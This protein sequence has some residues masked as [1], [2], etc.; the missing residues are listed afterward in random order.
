MLVVLPYNGTYLKL[1]TTFSCL[2]SKNCLHTT[3]GPYSMQGM[4][5]IYNGEFNRLRR[6][7]GVA[8]FVSNRIQRPKRA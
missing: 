5:Y 7:V 4:D 1:I 2:L 3:M 8:L 6:L